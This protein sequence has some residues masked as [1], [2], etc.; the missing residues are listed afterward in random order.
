MKKTIFLAELINTMYKVF[1]ARDDV[2]VQRS[3]HHMQIGMPNS[4]RVPMAIRAD[5]FGTI[6]NYLMYF[7]CIVYRTSKK[8]E[9]S[10]VLAVSTRLQN[11]NYR[12]LAFRLHMTLSY[13]E[14]LKKVT[15]RKISDVVSHSPSATGVRHA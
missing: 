10:H 3:R 8:Q 2:D 7:R 11:V 1:H 12:R 15:A 13:L 4:L 9:H 6:I 14:F 5:L